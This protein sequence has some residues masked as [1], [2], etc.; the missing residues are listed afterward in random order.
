[1]RTALHIIGLL[2]LG[3]LSR[4]LPHPPNM[5]AI[6]AVALK[7][8]EHYGPAGSFIPLAGMLISDAIIGFYDWRL[9]LSVY[10]SLVLFG[11][12][13]SILAKTRSTAAV[14]G[15]AAL[16]SL[17]FFLIT[18]TT[19]WALS[20]W[21]PHTPLGLLACLAAG[22]PFLASMLAGDL[23]FSLALFKRAR[24]LKSF[25]VVPSTNFVRRQGFCALYDT[26]K[27][28]T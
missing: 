22:L 6:G 4:L 19:V 5:T 27:S 10:A 1:M 24:I 8:R 25:A 2:A 20:S 18:N 23:F 21:Y 9:L 7:S 17:L 15:T 3:T 16:G 14:A 13:G 12:L 28:L 26:S 11:M